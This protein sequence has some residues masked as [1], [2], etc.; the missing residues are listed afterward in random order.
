M[1]SYTGARLN[2]IA[3]YLS[4]FQQYEGWWININEDSEDKRLKNL[5]SHR[6]VPLHPFLVED[7]GIR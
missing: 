6:L 1:A 4:D 2:K 7:L 3:H 5:A